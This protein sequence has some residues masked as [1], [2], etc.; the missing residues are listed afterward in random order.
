MKFYYP[1]NMQAPAMLMLWKMRDAVILFFSFI[2][3]AIMSAT[4]KS[5]I[6]MI[7]PVLYGILTITFPDGTIF[8]YIIKLGRFVITQQQIYFWRS[9]GI[10]N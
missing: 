8:D 7:F 6:P 2:L 3:L 5:I 4:V 1:D 9:G 10:D